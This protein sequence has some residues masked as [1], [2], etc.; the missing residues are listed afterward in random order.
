MTAAV[1]PR[2]AVRRVRSRVHH[3]QRLWNSGEANSRVSAVAAGAGAADGGGG[4]GRQQRA[5]DV[6]REGGGFGDSGRPA[7]P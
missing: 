1:R 3:G 4:G 7:K 5:E 2:R 6:S